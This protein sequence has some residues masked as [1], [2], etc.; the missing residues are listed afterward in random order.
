MEIVRWGWGKEGRVEI[1]QLI[2]D[3]SYFLLSTVTVNRADYE[4]MR[5]R[6]PLH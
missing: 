1:L 2:F 6:D 5:K 4:D 3:I